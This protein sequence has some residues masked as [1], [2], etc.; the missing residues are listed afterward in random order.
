M[1]K[2]RIIYNTL[3]ILYKEGDITKDCYERRKAQMIEELRTYRNQS[4]KRILNLDSFILMLE[5]AS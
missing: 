1:E 5:N 3:T 4:T 2:I